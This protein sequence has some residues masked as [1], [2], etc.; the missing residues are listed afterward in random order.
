MRIVV[1]GS[2]WLAQPLAQALQS[3]DHQVHL[4]T[5]DLKKQNH[6]HQQGLKAVIYQIGEPLPEPVKD[7]DILI[8]ATPSKDIPT[9]QQLLKQLQQLPQLRPIFISSTSVYA[10]DGTTHNESSTGLLT[11][12]P[13]YQIEQMLQQHPNTSVIRCGGLIGPNRHPG[14]FFAGKTLTNPQ[15]P[16]NLLPQ[17]DALGVVLMLVNNGLK[18]IVINACSDDHPAKGEY[19]PT[20]TKQLKLPVP[21]IENC[22]TNPGKVVST[23]HLTSQLNYQFQGSIWHI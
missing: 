6:L 10:N 4:T 2:G 13:L 14:R 11:D 19:Y 23:K 17:I 1:I 9:H 20:M 18:N 7:A 5:R 16:V 22:Q 8:I 15:A 12:S 21:T 3:Q